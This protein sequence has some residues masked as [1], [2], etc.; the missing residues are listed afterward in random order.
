VE[1]GDV[2]VVG[3]NKFRTVGEAHQEP[4]MEITSASP[5][6]ARDAAQRA[7]R[8][9]RERDGG[10]AQAALRA[11]SAAASGKGNLQPQIREAVRAYCTVGEITSALKETFG[12]YQPPTRF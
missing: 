8:V 10:K 6:A 11:L 1:K 3:V 2:P 12:A 4:E 5:E 7:A 9:R